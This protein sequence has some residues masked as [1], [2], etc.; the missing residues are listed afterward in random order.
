MLRA[1]SRVNNIA[2]H[3]GCSRQTSHTHVNRY[4]N[5]WSVSEAEQVLV[6]HMRQRYE[7]I[8]LTHLRNRF[9]QQ[10][11]LLGVY[12]V[13]AQTTINRFMQNNGPDIFQHDNARLYKTRITTQF[14]VQN[15]VNVLPWSAFTPVM[16]PIEHVWV[17]WVRWP[18]PIFKS[19]R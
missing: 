3:F 11:F 5:T 14:L 6:A 19:I 9:Y 4:N 18:G 7:R 8:T 15:N 16:N 2:H 12:R 13:Y 17:D 10:P 1:G